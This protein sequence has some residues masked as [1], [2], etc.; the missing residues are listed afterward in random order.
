MCVDTKSINPFISFHFL[1]K[2]AYSF[3]FLNCEALGIKTSISTEL[4]KA[5]YL[6][7]IF[8]DDQAHHGA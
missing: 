2:H 5:G 7:A 6:P 3:L 8:R 4:L 1:S